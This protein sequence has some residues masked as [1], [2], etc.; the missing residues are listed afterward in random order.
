[1]TSCAPNIVPGPGFDRAQAVPRPE[2]ILIVD[3][4]A[5]LR[6][7][8]GACLRTAGYADCV[9]AGSGSKV[10]AQAILDRPD[11]IIM[12]VM[13]PGGNGLRALRILRT[14]PHTADIPVIMMSGFNFETMG[15]IEP[16]ATVS[17]LSKPFT[18]GELLEKAHAL[19]GTRPDSKPAGG[20]FFNHSPGNLREA[21]AGI[22]AAAAL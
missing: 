12:D 21:M 8:V 16:S 4:E 15:G 5:F 18:P 17:L 19:L 11:L 13:M 3:D 14:S 10:P 6:E 2:R 7:Y 22:P 9:F 20:S 1:M